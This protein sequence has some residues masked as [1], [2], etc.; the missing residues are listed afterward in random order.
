MDLDTN[1]KYLAELGVCLQI[2]MEPYNLNEQTFNSK[3]EE[4]MIVFNAIF[5]SMYNS[6]SPYLK[7]EA[8]FGTSNQLQE[9]I[10]KSE[11]IEKSLNSSVSPSTPQTIVVNDATD[12]EVGD[13]VIGSGF[14]SG[15]T[16]TCYIRIN[17][18]FV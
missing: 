18:Y 3:F 6:D 14:A 17:N 7:V 12:I 8:S 1:D 2:K 5:N 4:N 15:T 13:F 9:V 11:T 16:V 10:Y